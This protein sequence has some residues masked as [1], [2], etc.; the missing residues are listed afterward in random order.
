VRYPCVTDVS[1]LR[2]STLADL[3]EI[4]SWIS[5]ARDCELWAGWRVAFPIDR[6]SLAEA[7]GFAGDNAFS[8]MSGHD[9]VAFGQL[10]RKDHGR[11]H[12]AR[13]IVKP[14]LRG[15]GHGEELVAALLERARREAFA[16]VSL[17]VDS[18][19]ERAASL[20]LKAGFADAT[21]PADE[22]VSP[23]TRYMELAKP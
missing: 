22:P 18:A 19:N 8:R 2:P 6:A 4:A 21:R 23:G 10:V 16:C 1:E 5:T 12:L 15:R 9:L 13:L 7:I 3:D 11:G 20:Y 14:A 17:N